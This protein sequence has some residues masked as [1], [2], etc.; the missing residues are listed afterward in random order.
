[1]TD[2]YY[3]T[4]RLFITSGYEEFSEENMMCNLADKICFEKTGNK[5]CLKI[6]LENN[7]QITKS[8]ELSGFGTWNH[9]TGK[10]DIYINAFFPTTFSKWQQKKNEKK[11]VTPIYTEIFSL[12]TYIHDAKKEFKDRLNEKI[13]KNDIKDD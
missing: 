4:E 9:T 12:N 10:W 8:H 3:L 13:M 6:K 1:V 5:D 2:L 11:M 7:N